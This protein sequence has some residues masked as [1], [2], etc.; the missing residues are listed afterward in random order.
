M[1]TIATA[2][3]EGNLELKI[4]TDRKDELGTLARAFARMRDAIK[5]KI[6]ELRSEITERNQA[7]QNVRKL[8]EELELKVR[9][10]EL[11]QIQL[12][13]AL[14]AL[15]ANNKLKD[16]FL[17]NTSHELRTPLNGIIGLAESLIDGITGKLSDKTRANLAMIVS[18]GKRLATLVNDIL[19]FSKLRHSKIELQ[20]KPVGL[21]EI[22]DIVFTL[23]QPLI[24]NK[25]VQLVNAIPSDLPPAQADENRLQQIF[26]NLVGNAIKFTPKGSIEISGQVVNSHLEIVISDT[27]IG[28]PED[29]L[30]R[31][32]ESFEQA[33][34]STARE[35]GGTGIGLTITKQLIQLHNGDI[36]IT[37][38]VGQGSQFF[39]TLPISEESANPLVDTLESPTIFYSEE[40][41][42]TLM[43]T[44]SNEVQESTDNQFTILIVDDEPVNLQVINNYLLLQNYHVVQA[45]SGIETLTLIMEEGFKPDAILLDVMMP[46][47]TGYEV[48]RKIR[49]KWQ[50]DELPILFLT[51]KNQVTELVT[52]L[53]SGANDYLT[54]PISKHELLARLKM[55]LRLRILQTEAVRLA[56]VEAVNQMIMESLRYAK[57]IQSSLLPN[58]EQVTTYLPNSF[59]LWKPRDIVGGDIFYIDRFDDSFIVAVMDCTGH[60]IPGAFMTM[61]ALTHLRQII[62]DEGYRE[63]SEILTRLNSVVKK[64]LQQ[65]TEYATSDD[66]LDIALCWVKPLERALLFAGARLPLYYIQQDAVQIIKGDKQSLGYKKSDLNF[67]FT[68][69]TIKIEPD[70]YFYLSTDGF[71][72][73]IGGTKGFPFGNR[74]FKDLLLEHCHYPFNEQGDKLF[75]AFN[76]YKNDYDRLDDVTVLGFKV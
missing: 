22:V 27:G 18:S 1:T 19:D 38:T 31:V 65:D 63:P 28:I 10:M 29:K 76:D 11:Q 74:R 58:L 34:G 48:T 50:A 16:E 56:A 62:K 47:I 8:N 41:V 71:I 66:G 13:K 49:D 32:F 5:N 40:E 14:E 4:E 69:H 24:H 33:E 42:E 75:E 52:G 54:K 20:L 72:E 6:V 2:I 64:S 61:I 35:Y 21:H 73:Q 68:T 67:T 17:A 44:I 55:H 7:E 23:S 12:N 37:S 9:Q 3:A 57:S 53:E 39:F 45:T 43:T 51:A 36:W 60:G 25:P 70:R 15:E 46:K 26:H 30:D 59:F